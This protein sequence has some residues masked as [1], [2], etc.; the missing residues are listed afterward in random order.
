MREEPVFK[1]TLKRSAMLR[2][3][4]L[5]PLLI[6][7]ALWFFEPWNRKS[8][9]EVLENTPRPMPAVIPIGVVSA[10]SAASK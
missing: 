2:A 7:A 10:A 4:W 3:W 1:A 5:L 9:L 6:V 8:A